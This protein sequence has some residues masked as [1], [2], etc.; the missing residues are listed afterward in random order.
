MPR[1]VQALRLLRSPSASPR[2]ARTASLPNSS[3][4]TTGK[5]RAQSRAQTCRSGPHR[6]A[7]CGLSSREPGRLCDCGTS[8]IRSPMTSSWRLT[9]R[10][11]PL[12][13]SG[14]PLTCRLRSSSSSTWTPRSAGTRSAASSGRCSP[15]AR[16]RLVRKRADTTLWRCFIPPKSPRRPSAP[17]T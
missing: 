6:G 2:R 4:S 3:R 17:G 9:T 1:C 13:I 8:S 7:R 12:R 15:R 14:T 5:R 10:R 11:H 16:A